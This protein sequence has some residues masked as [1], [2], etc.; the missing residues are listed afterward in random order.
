[1][2][3]GSWKLCC[4]VNYLV[5]VS[6]SASFNSQSLLLGQFILASLNQLTYVSG[7]LLFHELAIIIGPT[8]SRFQSIEIINNKLL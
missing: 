4:S 2:P 3:V 6:P 7:Q 5:P 8:T 1:M